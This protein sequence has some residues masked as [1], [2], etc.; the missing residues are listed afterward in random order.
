M[1]ADV[2]DDRRELEP[3][4]LAVGEAVDRARLIEQRNREPRD[5]MGMF[6]PVVA[7]LGELDHAAAAD[8]RVAIDLRDLFPVPRDVVE[9][10]PLA[11]RQVAQRDLGGAKATQQLVEQDGAGDDQ[12]GAARFEPRYTQPL[13]Q[14]ESGGFLAD[15]ADG[16]GGEAPVAQRAS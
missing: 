3:L 4:A 15:V 2:V 9:D 1:D 6:R 13:L 10:H 11:Q 16:L 5:V 12:V 14:I 7:A 8:V